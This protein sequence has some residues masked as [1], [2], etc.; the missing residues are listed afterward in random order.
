MISAALM[1]FYRSAGRGEIHMSGE[2]YVH[3]NSLNQHFL[4]VQKS[5]CLQTWREWQT[6]GKCSKKKKEKA[7]FVMLIKRLI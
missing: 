7:V 2:L 5:V 3:E 1:L 4:R 6:Q